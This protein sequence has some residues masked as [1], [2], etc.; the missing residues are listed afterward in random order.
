[1]FF[2]AEKKK[3]KHR[4]MTNDELLYD[5][6]MDDED[7]KWVDSQRRQYQPRGRGVRGGAGRGQ[8]GQGR[9]KPAAQK[10]PNSDAILNCPACMTTLCLDCQR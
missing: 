8:V 10:L 9:D 2:P 7:Q 3:I 4:K 5:P 1:M 6:N